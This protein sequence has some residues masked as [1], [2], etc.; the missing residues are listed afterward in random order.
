MAQFG[1]P[2]ADTYNADGYTDEA[3]GSTNIYG[4]IDEVVQA[5]ADYIKSAVAP[6]SDVYVTKLTNLEDPQ[7]SDNHTLRYAYGKDAVGGAQI[8]ITVQLRQDYVNEAGQGTLIK[9]IV[10]TNVDSGFTLNA[11]GLSSGE[12]DS[13][14][15]YTSLY[16]R[17]VSN[18]V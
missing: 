13:I 5:D 3:G 18:Q 10:H 6:S 2:S 8:D 16:V 9:E 12:A 15:D 7:S 14:T 11:Y 1:R 4:S 17:I